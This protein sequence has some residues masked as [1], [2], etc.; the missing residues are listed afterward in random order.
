MD[1]DK[2]A[3]ILLDINFIKTG[4][5]EL[6]NDKT[7]CEINK[8][9]EANFRINNVLYA[10]IVEKEDRD[11]IISYIGKTTQ[12]LNQRFQG[13][14][15]PGVSQQTNQRVNKAILKELNSGNR[16][17]IYL[18]KDV[19]PLNWGGFN[20]NIASGL[21]DSL[22]YEISPE[23]NRAGTRVVTASEELENDAPINL[24][25]PFNI[26]LG[27]AYFNFG[28]MNPGTEISNHMGDEGD[29]VELKL[30]NGTK[31]SSKIDRTSNTNAAARLYFGKILANYYQSNYKLGDTLEALF[32]I[33][34]E[35]YAIEIQ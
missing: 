16:V 35:K 25:M 17:S 7:R 27:K 5:W 4:S 18:F 14:A 21:E 11:E 32:T 2:S 24:T 31:L 22:V 1:K 6:S 9:D 10:F 3:Q 34:D 19:G 15:K 20:L 23:W 26:K 29:K 33:D 30:P 12:S 8:L 13:Y 28:Y